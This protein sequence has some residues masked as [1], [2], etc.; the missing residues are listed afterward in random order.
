VIGCARHAVEDRRDLRLRGA[1]GERRAVTLVIL[2]RGVRAN[3]AARHR[4]E[5]RQRIEGGDVGIVLIMRVERTHRVGVPASATRRVPVAE[6]RFLRL[7]VAA[8]LRICRPRDARSG[9]RAET[10]ERR[11]RRR[12]VL[13]AP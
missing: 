11:S 5:Q 10:R 12:N 4:A 9:R 8:L 13:I 6:Q 3:Q 7:Q 2:A 1:A